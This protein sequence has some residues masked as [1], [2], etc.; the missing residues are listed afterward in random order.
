MAR[1]QI[2]YPDSQYAAWL[3]KFAEVADENADELNLTPEQ[4]TAIND[5]A[6]EFELAF[7]SSIAAKQY[8]KG[9]SAQKRTVRTESE[10]LVRSVARVISVNDAISDAL[11]SK[12][13]LGVTRHTSGPVEAVSDVAA[14]AYSSGENKITWNRGGN[15][16][17][18]SFIIE[19]QYDSD[20]PW[21][22]VGMTTQCKYIHKG[23]TP[24]QCVQYRIVSQRA[25]KQS[26]VSN[27][28][29]VYGSVE[30]STTKL[31]AA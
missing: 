23:Q 22:Y 6:N 5:L 24:G 17:G 31:K 12:L 19:A 25:G 18:T 2:P 1:V 16:Q 13:G 28:A 21:F 11:K 8:A 7:R 3:S 15:A 20:S 9:E 30:P 10:Q 29:C 4:I 26:S 14:M 27:L